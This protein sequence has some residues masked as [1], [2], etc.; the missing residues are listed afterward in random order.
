[1]ETLRKW[2][3]A[4]RARLI[5]DWQNASRYWSIRFAAIGAA[6]KGFGL[7]FPQMATDAWNSIPQDLRSGLPGTVLKALPFILFA[8]VIFSRVTKQ[9]APGDN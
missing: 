9:K 3:D 7:A 2:R 1:M 8:L 5:D 6:L 4:L